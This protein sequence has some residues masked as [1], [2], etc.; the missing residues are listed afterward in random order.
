MREKTAD[1][2]T[3]ELTAM[4][5]LRSVGEGGIR[6]VAAVEIHFESIR[7]ANFVLRVAT[8]WYWHSIRSVACL[9]PS[10]GSGH[11]T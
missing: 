2:P 5:T 9:L 6:A 7:M 4:C 11:S 3:R 1:Q 8:V 10:L